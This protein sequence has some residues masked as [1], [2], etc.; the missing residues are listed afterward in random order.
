MVFAIPS[1]PLQTSEAQTAGS[2]A[3]LLYIYDNFY[4]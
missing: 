4:K 2:V 1:Q 3:S